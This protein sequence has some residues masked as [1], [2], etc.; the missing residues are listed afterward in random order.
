MFNSLLAPLT[1]PSAPDL[2]SSGPLHLWRPSEFSHLWT[3]L[4]Q[5]TALA[6]VAV[7]LGC[8][9]TSWLLVRLWRG[10]QVDPS[11]V[12]FGRKVFDGVLFPLLALLLAVGMRRVL[13]G[14]LP[15]AV[16]CDMPDWLMEMLMAQLGET[17]LRALA[18]GLLQ[19]APLDLRVNI[20]KTSRD[21]ARAR[22]SADGITV[23]DTP[24]SPYG[25]RVAGKPPINRHPLFV[26]GALEVQDEGSQL[27]CTLLGVRRGQMV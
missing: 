21:E 16:A 13:Q 26:T 2:A 25:L 3:Q 11:S 18:G 14:E 9:G 24:Y 7:L 5:P 1:S 17:D 10:K 19:N 12:W 20:A 4:N 6:E 27:L 22:L 15:L 8:L 23:T